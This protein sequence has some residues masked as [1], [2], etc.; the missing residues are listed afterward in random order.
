MVRSARLGRLLATGHEDGTVELQMLD[1]GKT[2]RLRER[3]DGPVVNLL[4][5]PNAKSMVSVEL[6]TL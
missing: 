6:C 5:S 4:F 2:R 3:H 1:S